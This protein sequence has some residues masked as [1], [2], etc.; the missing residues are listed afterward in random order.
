MALADIIQAIK[1]QAD[2]EI[3]VIQDHV[4]REKDEK[5]KAVDEELA[6]FESDLKKKTEEKKQQLKRKAETMV[7][8]ERRQILLTEK[9]AALDSVYDAVLEEAVKLPGAK[10]KKLVD[11]LQKQVQGRKGETKTSK[12]GGFTFVSEKT[13]EDFTFPHLVQTVLR[14]QTEIEVSAKLFS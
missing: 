9:R 6:T 14:P 12:E 13:E 8:M 2:K 11:A 3:S 5:K 7:E 10:T 4:L 1:A